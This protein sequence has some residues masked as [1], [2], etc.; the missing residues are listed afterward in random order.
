M[1][2]NTNSI[3]FEHL[4]RPLQSPPAPKPEVKSFPGHTNPPPP[5][6]LGIK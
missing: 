5:L 4:P 6:F 2:T 1:E 3:K